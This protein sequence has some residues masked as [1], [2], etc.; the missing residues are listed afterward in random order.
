MF[1]KP[2]LHQCP[3]ACTLFSRLS[4]SVLQYRCALHTV[5]TDPDVRKRSACL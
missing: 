3:T 1:I 5:P 2:H 4:W